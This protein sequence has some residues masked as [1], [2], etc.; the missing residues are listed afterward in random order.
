MTVYQSAPPPPVELSPGEEVQWT[1]AEPVTSFGQIF[2]NNPPA[3]VTSPVTQSNVTSSNLGPLS[4]DPAAVDNAAQLQSSA[5]NFEATVPISQQTVYDPY[6]DGGDGLTPISQETVYDP[7]GDGGDGLT[8]ISQ[9]APYDPYGDGGDGLTMPAPYD[10]YGDGGDGLTMPPSYT[11]VPGTQADL[12]GARSSAGKSD[13]VSFGGAKDWRVKLKLAPGANYLY[14]AP[15]PGILKPL[16]DT[17][18]IIFPYTP[19]IQVAY[20]A[21]YDNSTLTHSNY[22]IYQYGSSS[23]DTIQITCEFTAQDTA[24]ANYLLAV[25]HFFKSVTKMFYGQDKDPRRGTPPP[26]C[27]L[28]GLGQFQFDLH[29]LAVTAFN[30]SLPTDVD[31][32]RAGAGAGGGG[33]AGSPSAESAPTGPTASGLLRLLSSG[34][35]PGAA[36]KPATFG[37]STGSNFEATYV[38][39]KMQISI[40]AIPIITRKD[41]SETFSFKDYATGKLLQGSKRSGG[42]IW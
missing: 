15:S 25:I 30:Y 14:K 34:L 28:T 8:P 20:A 36:P 6:S 24:E 17:D 13:A 22:K 1:A 23:V 29:P 16:L 41:I 37:K 38:P 11:A 12:Q 10:P 2:A 18:G 35:Y 9:P 5:G 31:Y 7:Y 42:G 21:H 19:A 27:Y 40:T 4:T 33:A 32:V 39:S 3:A 26:L